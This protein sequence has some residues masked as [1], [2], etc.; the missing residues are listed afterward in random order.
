MNIRDKDEVHV[1]VVLDGRPGHEKQS[2]GIVQGLGQRMTVSTTIV[3][4]SK[5]GFF[6]Q[7]QSYIKLFF[8]L[9]M[10]DTTGLPTR[11]DLVIGAGT[12]THT[13]V[14]LLKKYFQIPAVTCMTP[15]VHLRDLFDICFVPEHDGVA[16]RDNYFLTYGAPNTNSNKGMHSSEKGLILVG[17]E[18][19]KSHV[20]ESD[21][22]I[23]KIFKVVVKE[24]DIDWVISSSPRTPK[25]TVCDIKEKIGQFSSCTFFDFKDTPKGWVEDQYDR[26]QTVWVTTDSIS[27]LYEALSSG[28]IV[29]VFPMRW[30]KDT[31]KF[32]TNE[33]LLIAKKLVIP[34]SNWENGVTES[35]KPAQLNE[36]QRCADYILETCW[37]KN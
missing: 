32:K 5:R 9:Q 27:M 19:D 36:A 16:L 25:S 8:G 35:I 21:E 4:V 3:D 20:W 22:I 11:A 31:S 26:C 30:K 23:E 2:L 14:L 24:Q 37:T 13:T 15:G 28:C 6:S 18:D 12:R 10:G 29:N 34:F 17:G 33:D 1:V 7:L